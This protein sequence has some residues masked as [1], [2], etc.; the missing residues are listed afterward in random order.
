MK[1]VRVVVRKLI[2]VTRTGI[3][4]EVL[5]VPGHIYRRV[6]WVPPLIG[7]PPLPGL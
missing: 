2:D 5:C 1:I 7:I 4:K 6:G 3:P